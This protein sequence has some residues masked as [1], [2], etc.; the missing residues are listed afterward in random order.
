MSADIPISEEN[1]K[2]DASGRLKA[3][4]L[5]RAVQALSAAM[6][7]YAWM[8]LQQAA[9]KRASNCGEVRALGHTKP[10]KWKENKPYFE[11]LADVAEAMVM[12]PGAVKFL[13]GL[14]DKANVG[15]K[16]LEG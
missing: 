8:Y 10:A 9:N 14:E 6:R 11:A 16:K 15:D 4:S 12:G 1:T 3:E 13:R 2:A 5:G 7:E